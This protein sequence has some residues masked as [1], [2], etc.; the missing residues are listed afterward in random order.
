MTAGAHSRRAS[1]ALARMPEIDPA[2]A[3]LALWC[4]HRDDP[5][6]TR[7]RGDTILYGPEF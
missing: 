6:R 5:G 7:T 1:A 2:I 4:R 3:A